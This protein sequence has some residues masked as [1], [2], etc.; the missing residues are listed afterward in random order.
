LLKSVYVT[1]VQ[2]KQIA[3]SY[4]KLLSSLDW[5]DDILI[6]GL[7]EGLTKFLSNAFLKSNGVNKY[8]Q[9]DFYTHSAL[10]LIEKG[11]T[12]GLVYEHMVP[13]SRYIQKPCEERAQKK[14][15]NEDYV[16]EL[17]NRYWKIAIVTKEEDKKLTRTK[18]PDDWDEADIRIRYKNARI[19]LVPREKALE[20]INMIRLNQPVSECKQ[21]VKFDELGRGEE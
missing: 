8:Y 16:I 9:G 13:K 6:T 5:E 7:R 17:L 2:K 12:S 3:K 11:I 1:T 14:S 20:K 4:F 15:L 18:M 19:D 21:A 10:D